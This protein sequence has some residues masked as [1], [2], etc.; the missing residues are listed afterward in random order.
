MAPAVLKACSLIAELT[1]GTN[2]KTVAEL[3]RQL[4]LPK[5][6]V[7][8]LCQTL[9]DSNY[10]HRDSDFRFTLAGAM[11][12]L[13]RGLFHGFPLLEAFDRAIQTSERLGDRSVILAI[14]DGAD[15]AIAAVHHGRVVL[16]ITATVGL[17]LPAWTTASGLAL[18]SEHS[19]EELSDLLSTPSATALGVP[20]SVPTAAELFSLIARHKEGGY[21]VDDQQTAVGLRGVSAPLSLSRFAKPIG[22]LTIATVE[23][24]DDSA[25]ELKALGAVARAA[26]DSIVHR[27]STLRSS[28]I[29]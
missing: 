27:A 20:G 21:F 14:L 22:A 25:K 28:R 23:E 10:L 26:A 16:P 1:H 12:K 13:S 5:S 18:L 4:D 3:A 17:Y 9:A 11:T 29:V 7:V 2:P 24:G 6:T 19:V 15:I 8:D